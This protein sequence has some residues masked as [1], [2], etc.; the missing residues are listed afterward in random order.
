MD[1]KI[2]E[3]ANISFEL[4][5]P[6]STSDIIKLNSDRINFIRIIKGVFNI[7][8]NKEYV[9]YKSNANLFFH[10][11]LYEYNQQPITK[12]PYIGIF[13]PSGS[14]Y[15]HNTSKFLNTLERTTQYYHDNAFSPSNTS[16]I[17]IDHDRIGKVIIVC[18]D[19]EI[20]P[21]KGRIELLISVNNDIASFNLNL[22]SNI[23]SKLNTE[24]IS[25]VDFIKKI[26]QLNGL[27]LLN[28]D[29]LKLLFDINNTNL[30]NEPI[31]TNRADNKQQAL[32]VLDYAGG[33]TDSKTY[34]TSLK[35][36]FPIDNKN[37]PYFNEIN[38]KLLQKNP[39]LKNINFEFGI[40]IIS[41]YVI[42]E[43]N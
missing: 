3:L 32:I 10:A 39:S 40:Q 7:K 1:S 6:K 2:I 27:E 20:S 11:W 34:P 14:I 16:C 25:C 5:N 30:I 22:I 35:I 29:D 36:N 4:N 31:T 8:E 18:I 33:G 37:I 12:Y 42:V 17:Y 15:A 19:H 23:L 43:W 24:T 26:S 41:P 38:S 9:T 21:P 28:S 13:H